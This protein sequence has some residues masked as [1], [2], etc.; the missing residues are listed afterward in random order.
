VPV[1]KTPIELTVTEGT[2]STLPDGVTIDVRGLLYAHRANSQ[3][4]TPPPP[5]DLRGAERVEVPLSRSGDEAEA[6]RWSPALG[7]EFRLEYADPYRSPSTVS[8]TVRRQ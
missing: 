1:D 6:D 4:L 2:P 5:P 7:W 8:I 3:N